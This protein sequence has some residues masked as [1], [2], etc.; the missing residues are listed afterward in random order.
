MKK[1]RYKNEPHAAVSIIDTASDGFGIARI[2]DK[3]VFVEQAIPGDVADI[4][5]YQD[6]KKFGQARLSKLVE[7][8]A[9]RVEPVCAHFG[10]CGGCKWQMMDYAG[11]L[12]FKEKQVFDALT[13]IGHLE[14]AER[15]PIIGAEKTLEFRNKLEFTFT[16]NRWLTAAE[17]A[18]PAVEKPLP[19]LGFH[20][21]GR[22]DRILQVDQCHLMDNRMNE[23]RNSLYQLVYDHKIPCYDIRGHQGFLRTLTIR[24]TSLD[25][26]MV[27]VMF[28]QPNDTFI[29]MVM[30]HLQTA[31]PW[32]TSLLYVINEKANETLDGQTVL[33]WSGEAQI[34]ERFEDIE[35]IISPKSFFQTNSDQALKLYQLTRDFAGLTGKENVYDLYT[36]TGS[37]AL[38]VA[39]HAVKVVGVEYVE[40]AVVDARK[41]AERNGITNTSFFA[42]DMKD[43]LNDE[44]IAIHG[45]PDVVITDPPRAGMHPDVVAMLNRL[46]APRIVYVSCNPATQ[47][48]D[49]DLMREH[50]RLVKYQP[51]DMF[52]QTAHVE[53]IAL[54]ER[55]A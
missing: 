21:P 27:L 46:G 34:V 23:V 35:Y 5:I 45:K 22:F 51:V 31:F 18:D 9:Y 39:K 28:G 50:Y 53:N 52:P 20:L 29:P 3:V 24:N 37:I 2:G 26:W 16:H 43:L 17:I 33:T 11:Q 13:R 7:P 38:F 30:N 10:V 54:L 15:T 49:L 40:D 44:F 14:I 6:K 36:G 42:G 25:Q 55:I 1:A 4:V 32:I 19:G 47:A 48:R 12:K 41:N 8:S